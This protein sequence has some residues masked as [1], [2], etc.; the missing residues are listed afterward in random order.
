VRVGRYLRT[1]NI[2]KEILSMK[3]FNVYDPVRKGRGLV[4]DGQALAHI[5]VRDSFFAWDVLSLPFFLRSC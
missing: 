5:E 1:L 3:N 2:D 4:L